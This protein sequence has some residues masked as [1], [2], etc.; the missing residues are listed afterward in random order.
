MNLLNEDGE[1]NIFVSV[2]EYIYVFIFMFGKIW[3]LLIWYIYLFYDLLKKIKWL[4]FLILN[5]FY[6]IRNLVIICSLYILVFI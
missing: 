4:F 3:N 1:V 6:F 2:N 5:Y